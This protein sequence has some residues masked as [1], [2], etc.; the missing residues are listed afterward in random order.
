MTPLQGILIALV[1]STALFLIAVSWGAMKR[2]L[3]DDVFAGSGDE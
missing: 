2:A 1:G 3:S